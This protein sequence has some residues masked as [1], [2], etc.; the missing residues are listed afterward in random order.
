MSELISKEAFKVIEGR[1]VTS[2]LKVAEYFGKPHNDVLKSIRRLIEAKAEF[3]REGNFSLTEEIK[4]LGATVRK[5]PFYWMD[6]KGFAI[7]AMGFT[8]AKAL[9]F[10]CAFYDEFER[11]E[12]ALHPTIDSFDDHTTINEAQQREIQRAVGKRAAKTK[13]FAAVYRA[14]KNH[15]DIPRYT[16]LL[17]KDFEEAIAFIET[18]EL[19]APVAPEPE[20]P[21]DGRCPCCGLT[22]LPKDCVVLTADEAKALLTFIYY[23]RFVCSDAFERFHGMLRLMKSPLAGKIWDAF[24]E[25]PWTRILTILANNGYDIRDMDCYKHWLKK[26]A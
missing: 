13:C 16:C 5:T 22:P 20:Q 3:A 1:P 19:Q 4:Q 26:A 14:L 25:V 15:F 23:V 17:A 2:S 6:R 11:M 10:K 7:L 12:K 9:D 18:C 21:T 24:H 8:G